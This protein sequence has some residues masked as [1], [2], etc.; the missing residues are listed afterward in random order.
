MSKK[1]GPIKKRAAHFE[2]ARQSHSLEAAE[3]YTELVYDLIDEQGEA[4]TG[5][6]AEHL[7]ISH[8]TALRTIQRLQEQGYL[9]TEKRRPV[10]LTAKGR[11]LARA[12][13]ARHELLVKFFV[14]IGVPTT[15]AET[16][17]EGMEHHV[18]DITLSKIKLFLKNKS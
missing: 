1:N 9:R 17:V 10:E 11:R 15:V 4:R 13:K 7:G 18:S 16:D 6:I 8:V 12:A 14:H 2:A 3:D 5:D